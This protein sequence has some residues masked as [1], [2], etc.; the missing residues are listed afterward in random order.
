MRRVPPVDWERFPGPEDYQPAAVPPALEALRNAT[1]EASG[2]KAYHRVLYAVGN[3]HRGTLYPA[4]VAVVGI[5][6]EV[7]RTGSETA[8]AAALET[9]VELASFCPEPGFETF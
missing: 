5:V 7:A 3:N 8:K 1:D 2:Q 6:F 9:A 4:A